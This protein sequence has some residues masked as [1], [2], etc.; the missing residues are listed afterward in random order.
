MQDEERL[1]MPQRGFYS[2]PQVTW[3]KKTLCSG[4]HVTVLVRSS[5]SVAGRE[6]QYTD[7]R[8]IGDG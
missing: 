2:F 6:A 7:L 3:P 4:I 5:C 1:S 8:N